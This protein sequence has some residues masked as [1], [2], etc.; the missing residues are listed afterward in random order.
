M[1]DFLNV[2]IFYFKVFVTCIVC[3]FVLLRINGM[4]IN[5]EF[6]GH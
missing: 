4:R 2:S 3:L 1:Y 6:G 5:V